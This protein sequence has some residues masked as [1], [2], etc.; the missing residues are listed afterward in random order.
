M[1]DGM[2]DGSGARE[3]SDADLLNFNVP[4][5]ALEIAASTMAGPAFS[6]PNAPTVSVLVTCCDN[7]SGR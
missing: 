4:D 2:Q 7:N 1:G 6:F 3:G 5:E